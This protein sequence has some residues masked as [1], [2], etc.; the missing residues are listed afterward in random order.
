MIMLTYRV[1]D[2]QPNGRTVWKFYNDRKQAVNAA[3]SVGA[4]A[5][6]K[7]DGEWVDLLR[8]EDEGGSTVK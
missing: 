6:V 3:N 1:V 7:I 8:W 5:E 2:N 4:V